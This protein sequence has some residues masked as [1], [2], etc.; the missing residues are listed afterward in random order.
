MLDIDYKVFVAVRMKS[1]RLLRK[2]LLDLHGKPVIEVLFDYLKI[3]IPKE[4]I[5]I[6]T[7]ELKDDDE[8]VNF[9]EDKSMNIYRGSAD[10][11]IHRFLMA[12]RDYPAQH[13]VRVTGDNPLTDPYLIMKMLDFHTKGNHDYTFTNS[14]PSGTRAEII[15]TKSL[16]KIHKKLNAP[17][18]SEYMTYMLNRP[19]RLNVGCYVEENYLN[20]YPDV[21]VTLDNSKDYEQLKN[22]FNYFLDSSP[23]P[24]NLM[25]WCSKNHKDCI[26]VPKSKNQTINKNI[27]GYKDER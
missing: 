18:N 26:K 3:I 13:I 24:E 1:K 7:S 4:K 25:Q 17:E 10:D 27:Y 14:F 8:L 9:C 6:C 21:S 20:T 12:E 2:A 11:V 16:R 15:K 23:S 22:I 5:V 19:D